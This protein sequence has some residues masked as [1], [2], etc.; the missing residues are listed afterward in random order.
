VSK[1]L[2][3][4][5]IIIICIFIIIFFLMNEKAPPKKT[6]FKKLKTLGYLSWVP[7]DDNIQKS[8]V[9]K[10]NRHKT[11]KGVN[12]YSSRNKHE[13][14]LINM[15]GKILHSWSKGINEKDS[16]HHIEVCSNGDLLVIIKDNMMARLDWDS[17]V[18]WINKNR[19]HHD[20]KVSENS[21]I[22]SIIRRERWIKPNFP[23]A[24]LDD[25]IIILSSEGKVK[26]EISLYDILKNEIPVKK[27]SRL[28]KRL[29]NKKITKNSKILI[30]SNTLEDVFHTNSLA[31]IKRDVKGL[32][33]KGNLLISIRELNL[34]AVLDIELK[35]IVWKWGQ[36]V[37]YKQHHPTLLDNGN[38]LVF[39]N[40]NEKRGYSRVIEVNPLKNKIIW[41]YKGDSKNILYSSTRGASQQLPNGNILITESNKGH[42]FE[43]NKKGKIVWDFYNP[44]VNIVKK[45]RASFYRMIKLYDLKM[46]PFLKNL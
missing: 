33:K 3:S 8:G 38:V 18:I 26:K 43:I 6:S 28:Y 16:W 13:A 12:I 27:F 15:S 2:L 11:Y 42:A 36:G 40:G 25:Y 17:N 30:E 19:F 32:F 9:V 1:K 5:F 34:I 24:I 20:I 41:E 7:A 35:K 21:D 10:Y 14:N 29:L 37:I 44:N 39:D 31:I 4:L 45:K 22:Y 23:I 46:Y